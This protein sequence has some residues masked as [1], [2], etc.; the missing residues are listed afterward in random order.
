MCQP[1]EV[2]LL[3]FPFSDLSAHKKRPV[4][5]LQAANLQGDFL[6]VQITSQ[7]GYE[8]ALLLE[9]HDFSLG[10]LPKISF[11]RPDKLVTLNKSLVIQRIG[12]LT[13]QAFARIREGVCA[14]LNCANKP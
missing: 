6:A 2:V 12:L 14:H 1:S 10:V 9:Q 4:L 3:P 7:P 8:T 11:V 5:I 13:D